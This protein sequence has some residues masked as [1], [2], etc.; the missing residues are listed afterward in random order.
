MKTSHSRTSRLSLVALTAA[1]ALLVVPAGQAATFKFGSKLNNTVQPSN[2]GSGHYCVE[3][4]HAQKC[5][6]LMNEAYGRPNGGEK[7]S[8]NG[9]I[10]QIRLIAQVKGSFRLLIVK[11][12]KSGDKYKAKVIVRGPTIK[13]KGQPDPNE[14]YKVETFNVHLAVHKG[15]RLAINTNK[16]SL[17]RC[18]SGGDNTLLYKP[19]LL[20]GQAF[21]KNTDDDGCWMLIEAVAKTGSARTALADR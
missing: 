19:P 4:N 8:K 2:A 13:Y 20:L 18:S 16:T 17:L 11:V 12:Q 14:P 6:W 5:T 21:R 7:S 15:E 1:A 10:R 3:S 9:T